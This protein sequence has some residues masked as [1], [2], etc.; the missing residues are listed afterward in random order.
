MT[1]KLLCTS[2]FFF[3]FK[4]R[5]FCR[6]HQG[7]ETILQTICKVEYKDISRFQ[8][9]HLPSIYFLLFQETSNIMCVLFL[10]SCLFTTKQLIHSTL[11][12][13]IWLLKPTV[14][15]KQPVFVNLKHSRHAGIFPLLFLDNAC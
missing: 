12:Y 6:E 7:I 8:F 5:K 11:F 14:L 4:Q 10:N 3:L 15:N 9:K 2:F 13:A 1:M